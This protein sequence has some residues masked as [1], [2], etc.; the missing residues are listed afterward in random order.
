METIYVQTGTVLPSADFT[1]KRIVADKRTRSLQKLYRDPATDWRTGST[2][3]Q[4]RAALFVTGSWK[5]REQN[6]K[7]TF[8]TD[9]QDQE[10]L[11]LSQML[12]RSALL[13]CGRNRSEK[14]AR[15][16]LS[17]CLPCRQPWPRH[18]MT[19]ESRAT[20]HLRRWCRGFS[21]KYF[22]IACL[23]LWTGTNSSYARGWNTS[24]SNSVLDLL[25][26]TFCLHTKLPLFLVNPLSSLEVFGSVYL[27]KTCRMYISKHQCEMLRWNETILAKKTTSFSNGLLHLYHLQSISLQ[28]GVPN[29]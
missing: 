6:W 2:A 21:C 8:Y 18:N 20:R 3:I 15:Q 17:H 28:T 13:T 24:L 25:Q 27:P 16:L 9:T 1:F 19:P 10:C 4:H 14:A 26:Q 11:R 5:A 29:N 12:T 23:I 7:N 22:S